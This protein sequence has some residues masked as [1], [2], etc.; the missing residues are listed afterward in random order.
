VDSLTAFFG[1]TGVLSCTDDG[2]PAYTG[3]NLDD[4]HS[5][6]KIGIAE[7]DLFNSKL[8]QVFNS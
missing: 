4:A 7:F 8:I 1:Q 2:F 3:Q 6:M 5:S